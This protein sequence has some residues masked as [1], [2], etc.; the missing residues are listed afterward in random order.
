MKGQTKEDRLGVRANGS[1]SELL[2]LP[3]G[4]ILAHGL[5]AAMACMLAELDPEDEV[6]NRRAKSL[7]HELPN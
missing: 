3:D 2:I 7:K 6:M 4:K 1:M 5:S